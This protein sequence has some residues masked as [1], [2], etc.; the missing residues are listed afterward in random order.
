MIIEM[1][2][3]YYTGCDCNDN[4]QHF[5]ESLVIYAVNKGIKVKFCNVGL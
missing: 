3:I 5:R 4:L 1:G 2:N